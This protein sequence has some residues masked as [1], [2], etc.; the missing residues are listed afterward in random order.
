MWSRVGAEDRLGN[1]EVDTAADLGWRRQSEAVVDV[2]RVLINAGELWFP[3]M[4]Q[5]HRFMVAISR[6]AVDEG[7]G[8]AASD[9]LVWDQGSRAKQRKVGIRVVVDL[10]T[11]LGPPGFLCGPWVQV[12]GGCITGADVAAWPESVHRTLGIWGITGSLIWRF[13]SL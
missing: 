13:D 4:Q 2:G 1:I 3:I 9:P 6:V 10:A 11:L 8:G 12:S 7:R 5:L